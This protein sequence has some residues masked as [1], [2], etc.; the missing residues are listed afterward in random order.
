MTRPRAS[1]HLHT[2]AVCRSEAEA[3][4]LTQPDFAATLDQWALNAERRADGEQRDLF[5]DPA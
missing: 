3:R 2:A 1:D 4:R 5:G